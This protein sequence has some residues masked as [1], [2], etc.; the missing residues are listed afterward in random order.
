VS[1]LS[2][3][4]PQNREAAMGATGIWMR[5][6]NLLL[7]NTNQEKLAFRKTFLHHEGHEEHEVEPLWPS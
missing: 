2:H 7:F 4:K 3:A 5:Q 6:P 1:Y